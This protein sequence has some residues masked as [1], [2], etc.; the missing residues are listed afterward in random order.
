MFDTLYSLINNLVFNGSALSGTLQGD[1]ATL[2][3][4]FGV[5]MVIIIPFRIIYNAVD[6]ICGG[7]K[8]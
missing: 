8:R 6:F 7:F 2:L 3:T 1:I 5:C 4:A